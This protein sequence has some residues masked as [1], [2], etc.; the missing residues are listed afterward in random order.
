MSKVRTVIEIDAELLAAA[1][2]RADRLGTDLSGV[3]EE[4]LRRSLG[5]DLFERLWQGSDLSEDDAMNLAR[6]S[7]LETRR[8]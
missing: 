7:Q 6:E 4:A 3:I 1:R 5:L 8:S 2:V